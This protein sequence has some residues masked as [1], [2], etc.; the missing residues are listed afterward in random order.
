MFIFYI[1]SNLKKNKLYKYLH[2]NHQIA[3]IT[4]ILVHSIWQIADIAEQ[5]ICTMKMKNLQNIRFI[6]FCYAIL[7][8]AQSISFTFMFYFGFCYYPNLSVLLGDKCHF[9]SKVNHKILLTN[10]ERGKAISQFH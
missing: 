10:V 6:L 2:G 1:L 8:T 5:C 7:K 3:S 9:S 4:F